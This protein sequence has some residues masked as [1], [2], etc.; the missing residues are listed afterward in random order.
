MPRVVSSS[1]YVLEKWWLLVSQHF[2]KK[3]MSPL[4]R[5]EDQGSEGTWGPVLVFQ[6]PGPWPSPGVHVRV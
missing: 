5:W 6:L 3:V 1:P 2:G 4:Y